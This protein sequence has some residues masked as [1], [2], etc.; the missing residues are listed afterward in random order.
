MTDNGRK[1]IK[2]MLSEFESADEALKHLAEHEL[3]KEGLI[4]Q[5]QSCWACMEKYEGVDYALL[6]KLNKAGPR[7]VVR[8]RETGQVKV[9]EGAS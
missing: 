3:V 2:R 6:I 7:F 8:R 9:R 1:L 4:K 5:I